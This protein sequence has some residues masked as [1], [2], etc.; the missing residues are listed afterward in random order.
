MLEGDAVNIGRVFCERPDQPF[1]MKNLVELSR[2]AQMYD[3]LQLSTS[4]QTICQRLF[5]P[6][7]WFRI[8]RQDSDL[9]KLQV[10]VSHKLGEYL[11]KED[12]LLDWG[13]PE[14]IGPTQLLCE[15]NTRRRIS[16]RT[17]LLMNHRCC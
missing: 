17:S 7:D 16:R 9:I 11:P 15:H 10:L 8:P 2:L 1:L 12:Q 3:L 5:S 14:Q 13:D 6:R 4:Q